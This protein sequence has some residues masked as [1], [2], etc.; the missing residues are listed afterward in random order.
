MVTYEAI[1]AIEVYNLRPVM[2]RDKYK[3]RKGPSQIDNSKNFM[4]KLNLNI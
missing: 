4:I 3:E 1:E 2:S